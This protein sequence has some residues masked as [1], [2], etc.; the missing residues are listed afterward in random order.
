MGMWD[1]MPPQMRERMSMMGDMNHRKMFGDDDHEFDHGD[2]MGDGNEDMHV[3][4]DVN[5]D[6][7]NEDNEQPVVF[8]QD[9]DDQPSYHTEEDKNPADIG[10]HI[11]GDIVMITASVRVFTPVHGAPV[12]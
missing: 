10:I 7:G 4:T 12:C 5:E 1:H 9:F 6:D 11:N 2:D 8:N 3:D